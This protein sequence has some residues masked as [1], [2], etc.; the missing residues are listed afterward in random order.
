MIYDE[1]R[2][3]P[4]LSPLIEVIEPT[5]P[6]N[7]RSPIFLMTRLE[8]PG[9]SDESDYEA[10]RSD[11]TGNT[12]ISYN[13]KVSENGDM[14]DHNSVACQN[15]IEEV[16]KVISRYETVRSQVRTF[17]AENS[18]VQ[19]QGEGETVEAEEGRRTRTKLVDNVNTIL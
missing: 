15:T 12:R 8:M 19:R 7:R 4:R 11:E 14:S 2:H 16:P 18:L 9:S 5:P 10:D 6:L 13:S 3:K 1:F 17:L